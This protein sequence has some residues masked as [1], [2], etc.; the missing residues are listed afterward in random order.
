MERMEEEVE[1]SD[2]RRY[3]HFLSHSPWDHVA[4]IRQVAQEASTIFREHRVCQGTPT[5]Y[6]IDESAHVKKGR[7]SVGGS[8]QYAGV[9]GKVDNSQVGV[10]ASLCND[11]RTTLINARLF[12]PE[13]WADDP[14]RCEQADIPP[15]ERPSQQAPT[16]VGHD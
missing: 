9:V 5:G 16:G 13:C 3:H 14:Q 11:T 6:L 1:G 15:A 7:A 10:Y 12:L 2:Y 8:R 4:V